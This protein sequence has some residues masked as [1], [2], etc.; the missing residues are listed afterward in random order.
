MPLRGSGLD[1]F[2]VMGSPMTYYYN[3]YKCI[4]KC[5]NQRFLQLGV[6]GVI[7]LPSMH[8]MHLALSLFSVQ[9]IN[10]IPSPTSVNHL[11][12]LSLSVRNA[13]LAMCSSISKLKNQLK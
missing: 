10:N 3:Q 9:P 7:S 6:S 11:V 2:E 4:F 1:K 12:A 8:P 13:S 5:L